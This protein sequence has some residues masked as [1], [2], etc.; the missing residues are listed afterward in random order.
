M[1]IRGQIA[2][3]TNTDNSRSGGGAKT[4][5]HAGTTAK[6]GFK[7][8]MG[9]VAKSVVSITKSATCTATTAYVLDS[10]KAV[11]ATSGAFAADVATFAT[12][13]VLSANV[14]YYFAVDAGGAGYTDTYVNT[15]EPFDS[16]DF[17]ITTGL[18]NN[19]ADE[20]GRT[21]DIESAAI[22]TKSPAAIPIGYL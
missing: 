20:A 22:R 2:S 15:A 19:G 6:S 7:F 17:S 5:T 11:L 10:T 9:S 1:S 12:P 3:I 14:E 13:Y 8:T 16:V 21:Y 18:A 4:L